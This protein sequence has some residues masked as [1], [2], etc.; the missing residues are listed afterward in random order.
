MLT[1]G[2]VHSDMNSKSD[3]FQNNFHILTLN[4]QVRIKDT[5][6]TW[7]VVQAK[8]LEKMVAIRKINA[9]LKVLDQKL[10]VIKI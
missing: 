1:L 10:P 2:E 6:K 8:K 7:F 5:H 3:S 9:E 4:K